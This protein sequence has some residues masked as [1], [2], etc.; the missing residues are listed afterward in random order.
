MK[1]RS[2]QF[3]LFSVTMTVVMGALILW[4]TIGGTK[5][6]D[7][8]IPESIFSKEEVTDAPAKFVHK[9]D[10]PLTME[11]S[12]PTLDNSWV[13]VK[14]VIIDS[15]NVA[16]LE[17]TFDLSYYYG[18]GWTEG[19]TSADWTFK[20]P[21]DSY[22]IL[23]Y[24]ENAASNLGTLRTHGDVL[25]L[26]VYEGVVLTRYFVFGFI[27]FLILTFIANNRKSADEKISRA[28][29]NRNALFS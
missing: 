24:G 5:I 25:K 4:S 9:K 19:N 1:S 17:H 7:T 3:F 23:V 21:A 10:G 29:A 6:A 27:A 11:V 18:P 13:W 2:E 28:Q 22:K 26:Q 20:L 15:K 12:A 14:V 8:Q 16:V